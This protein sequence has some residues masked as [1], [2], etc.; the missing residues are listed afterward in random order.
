M[1]GLMLSLPRNVN[2]DI[3]IQYRAIT[4]FKRVAAAFTND[5]ESQFLSQCRELLLA[6]DLPPFIPHHFLLLFVVTFPL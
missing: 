4:A 3:F 6:S 1:I 5:A 2:G